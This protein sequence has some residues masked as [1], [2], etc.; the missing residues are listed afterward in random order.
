MESIE[1]TKKKQKIEGAT[2]SNPESLGDPK[3]IFIIPFAMPNSGKSF[4]WKVLQELLEDDPT[5]SLG[6]GLWSYSTYSSDSIRKI[7][8]DKIMK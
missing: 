5:S 1:P 8:M 2:S 7:E 3:V 6:P 4:C